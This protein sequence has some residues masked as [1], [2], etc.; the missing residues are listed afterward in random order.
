MITPQDLELTEA[1]LRHA[2]SF[3]WT[4]YPADVLPL[5]VADMDFAIAP[6]IRAALQNRLLQSLGYNQVEGDPV[7]I[8]L[9]RQKL[10]TAGFQNLPNKFVRFL[11]GVVPCLGTAIL[12][13]TQP[14]DTVITMTP[15]YTPF[16]SAIKDHHRTLAE[17]SLKETPDRYEI[18]WPAMEVA[19]TEKKAKLL[20]LCHPH[21]PT[22]RVWSPTELRQLAAYCERHN[23]YIVSDELH[24]DLTFDGSH[25]PFISHA[26]ES[27]KQK[28]LTLTGPCKTYNTAGL[29]IGAIISH[30]ASLLTNV[31]KS[32]LWIAG[33]PTALS[34]AMWKAA[35]QDNGEWH[36]A[37]LTYLK[38][39][40]DLLE[41][42]VRRNL[43]NVKLKHTEATY[44]AWLDY[45]T[46][47]EA[48]HIG[49]HL[50]ETA[51]V[52]LNDG[53]MF[54]TGYEGF[55]R[56]NFAT[57]KKI[58]QEALTRLAADPLL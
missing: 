15:I 2:D 8:S 10:E 31:M 26:S 4:K 45:R 17:V 7:L 54:G 6:S 25:T 19:A 57:S 3:K 44:L 47:P 24:A 21:N 33:H 50:L 37:M 11:T 48:R 38:E 27:L 23:L 20:L 55:A 13:L 9:L 30:N 5:W 39:N 52:A 14:T 16:L 18:D 32:T 29:G 22:G 49:K 12:G 40:R 51:K 41:S 28:T 36:T 42:F 34:V 56:L 35:L 46:H 1:Q 43:P 53:P 58:L